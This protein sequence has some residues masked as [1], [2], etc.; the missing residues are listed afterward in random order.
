[1]SKKIDNLEELI[2]PHGITC[3]DF[4]AVWCGPCKIIGPVLH[5][6]EDDGVIEK[7]ISVDVDI[8]REMALKFGIQA[9]PYL[10]FYKDG[11]RCHNNIRVDDYDVMKDGVVIGA[12]PE[13]F[14][15]QVIS[16]L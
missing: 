6:L 8:N 1:M 4:T 5:N 12:L 13:N 14:M 7:V 10:V 16:Q 15:R 2:A 3:V 9:V 11:E